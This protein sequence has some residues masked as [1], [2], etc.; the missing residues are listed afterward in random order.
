MTSFRERGDKAWDYVRVQPAFQPFIKFEQRSEGFY[1]LV[2][3]NGLPSKVASNRPDGSYATKDLFSPHPIIP[4][5][6]KYFARM[7]DTLVL[8]NGEKVTPTAFEQLVRDNIYVTEAVMFGSGKTR[9]GMMIIPSEAA[10]D[11]TLGEV[12]GLVM[13]SLAKANETMPGYAQL[14]ADMVDILPYGTAYPRTDK[15]TVIRAA[16]YRV[17]DAQIEA[18]YESSEVSTG[19]L[20]LSEAELRDYIR[21]ELAKITA[22]SSKTALEDDTDFFSVGIDSLQTIQLR[23]VLSKNISTNGVKLASNIVFDFPSINALA[24]E[25]YRLRTGG[26]STTVSPIEKMKELIFKYSTFDA[27]V[28]KENAQEG[29]TLVVTGATGSLGAHIVSKLA[30]R[31]DVTKIYCLVR[32]K[33]PQQA[34]IRVTNSLR[35]R[36]VYHYLPLGARQKLVAIPSDFGKSTLGLSPDLYA[37]IS[38]NITALIHCAWSVNFNLGLG[39]FEADC[40]AGKWHCS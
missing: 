4:N 35:E 9:V 14:S 2:A 37:E 18:I 32:A 10:K 8:M 7:D 16:F 13:P 28:S 23:S 17:F 24:H 27:H 1:E 36:S 39:S 31:A 15:G 6:W 29:Q 40:I 3:L 22:Q 19:E 38:A 11:K 33:S 12:E 20:C 30:L 25:L 26:E 21:T 5:A 34:R